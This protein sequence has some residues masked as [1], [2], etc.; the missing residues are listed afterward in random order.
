[1]TFFCIECGKK[2]DAAETDIGFCVDCNAR[3]ENDFRILRQSEDDSFSYI[4][5]AMV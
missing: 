5:E 3:V 2:L 1:M 4:A